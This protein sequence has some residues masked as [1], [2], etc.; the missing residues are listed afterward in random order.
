MTNKKLAC[1]VVL[2]VVVVYLLNFR[3]TK[4]SSSS[5]NHWTVYGTNG[6]SWTR[7][8]LK[9][10]KDNK[11]SHTFINCDEKDCGN[12]NAFP[13]LKDSSGKKTEGFTLV[14]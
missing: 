6:C 3:L 5:S 7:K 1:A 12:I 14:Q 8:Q 2:F 11:I 10:M 13:T 9:H 4:N